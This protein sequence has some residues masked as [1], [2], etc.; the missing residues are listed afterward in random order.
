MKLE[1]LGP[2]SQCGLPGAVCHLP[3]M[4]VTVKD[5]SSPSPGL[6]CVV[7][8]GR[9]EMGVDLHLRLLSVGPALLSSSWLIGLHQRQH[10]SFHQPCPYAGVIPLCLVPLFPALLMDLLLMES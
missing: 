1:P 7:R 4:Q 5:T 8:V 6:L 2:Y 3:V 10:S 9:G